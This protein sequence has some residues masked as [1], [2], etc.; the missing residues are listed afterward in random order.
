MLI[1]SS[2][3][4]YLSEQML[5]RTEDHQKQKTNKL[6]KQHKAD[7]LTEYWFIEQ[8]LLNKVASLNLSG[9]PLYFGSGHDNKLGCADS[10]MAEFQ[11]KRVACLTRVVHAI[12]VMI[13][14][15]A[16]TFNCQTIVCSDS[17]SASPA[18]RVLIL[19]SSTNSIILIILENHLP[20]NNSGSFSHKSSSKM[21][22]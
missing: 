18:I 3:I 22:L 13:C 11:V 9:V 16:S 6:E 15:K 2:V 19:F 21:P 7:Q 5:T 14:G 10:Q 8:L 12:V 4:G 17:Q 1:G 20:M